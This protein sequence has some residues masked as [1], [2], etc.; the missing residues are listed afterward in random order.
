MA[1][2]GKANGQFRRSAS[3]ASASHAARSSPPLPGPQAAGAQRA[4][5]PVVLADPFCGDTPH[6]PASE[7][8]DEFSVT[9]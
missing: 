3:T 2:K 1:S 8:A 9:G 7:S 4:A 5:E 6:R